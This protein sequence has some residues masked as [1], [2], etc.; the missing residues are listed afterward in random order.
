MWGFVVA[1]LSQPV[2]FY[3]G[4]TTGQ[5]SLWSLALIFAVLHTRGILNNRT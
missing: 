2:W 4:W 1:L 3:V 5:W